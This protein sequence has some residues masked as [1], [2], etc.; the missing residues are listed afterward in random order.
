[1]TVIMLITIVREIGLENT[2]EVS[3]P[4]EDH[5]ECMH[6]ENRGFVQNVKLEVFLV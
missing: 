5:L 1:M 2:T 6:A 3:V 4:T